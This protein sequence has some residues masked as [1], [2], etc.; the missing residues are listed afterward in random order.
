MEFQSMIFENNLILDN[1]VHFS[2][3][4]GIFQSSK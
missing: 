1:Y 2:Y 4:N 3:Q